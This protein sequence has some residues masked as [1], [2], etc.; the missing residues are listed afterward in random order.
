ME[1]KTSEAFFRKMPKNC[2]YVVNAGLAEFLEWVD[3]WQVSKENL[4]YLRSCKNRA[5]GQLF[6]NDFLK[7]IDGQRLSVDI[8]AVPEGEVVFAGEPVLSVSGP[9]WQVEMVEAAYLNVQNAQAPIATNM[10]R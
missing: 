7:F 1:R 5:G 6:N 10:G 4:E 2:G 8:R 3:N 9:C